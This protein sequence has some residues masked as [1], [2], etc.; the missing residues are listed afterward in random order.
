MFLITFALSMHDYS[1]DIMLANSQT[2]M[3]A[4]L[5]KMEMAKMVSSPIDM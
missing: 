4:S 5:Q 3:E 1:R 2:E